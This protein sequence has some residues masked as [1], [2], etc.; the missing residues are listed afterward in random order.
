MEQLID[1]LMVDV[2]GFDP[3]SCYATSSIAS[4]IINNKVST[5]ANYEWE[6]ADGH[7]IKEKYGELFIE[8]FELEV[9]IVLIGV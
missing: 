1:K 4:K 3:K 7:V 8:F 5:T 2:E 6:S 9:L